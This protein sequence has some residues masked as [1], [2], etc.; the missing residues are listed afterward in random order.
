M[1]W[2]NVG[3]G[4]ITYMVVKV[5]EWEADP[6]PYVT[7]QND[8]TTRPFSVLSSLQFV[9]LTNKNDFVSIFSYH[10]QLVYWIWLKTNIIFL[11]L[12]LK[13]AFNA[14]RL[15]MSFLLF[16]YFTVGANLFDLIFMTIKVARIVCQKLVRE[17]TAILN[18]T[19]LLLYVI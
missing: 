12:Y 11:R 1:P 7:C 13:W 14:S 9:T 8:V 17:K 5:Y 3:K 19:V 16:T 15:T 6:R 18:K 10:S 2:N 4:N